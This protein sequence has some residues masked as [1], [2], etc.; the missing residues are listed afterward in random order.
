MNRCKYCG[1]LLVT[2]KIERS[3]FSS[4]FAKDANMKVCEYCDQWGK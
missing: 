2:V 3:S 4:P 1:E